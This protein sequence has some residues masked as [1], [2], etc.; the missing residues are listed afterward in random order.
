MLH[1]YLGLK[2]AHVKMSNCIAKPHLPGGTVM[3][4]YQNGIIC[5]L[6]IEDLLPTNHGSFSLKEN[7]GPQENRATCR[8]Q[9]LQDNSSQSNPTR[10]AVLPADVGEQAI[11]P[12]KTVEK[13][14]HSHTALKHAPGF[15]ATSKEQQVHL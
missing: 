12:P 15:N 4:R 2:T 10:S 14:L 8:G 7:E 3:L 13:N 1:I 11:T 9:D 6:C 5:S